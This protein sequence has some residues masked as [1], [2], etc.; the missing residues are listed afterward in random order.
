MQRESDDEAAWLAI[1]ENFGERARL[2]EPAHE[3]PVEEKRDRGGRPAAPTDDAAST[4]GSTAET[5]QP[6]AD[7]AEAAPEPD[8]FDDDPGLGAAW[9]RDEARER[10]R[11]RRTDEEAE[12]PPEEP[13][14]EEPDASAEPATEPGMEQDPFGGRNPW[15]D[16][17]EPEPPA[18]D[19]EDH[20][21][22]PSA[23]PLPVPEPDRGIAWLG[24][25]G[26]PIV[27]LLSLLTGLSFPSW[28]G[29]LL[30]AWF[31]GG[32]VYLVARM[33]REPRDPWDD[34]SRI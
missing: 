18:E 20:F 1:V 27:L 32:F 25:I 9:R 31:V 21:V 2:D 24:V 30:I 19:P 5:D 28:V 14:R 3:V 11:R 22:P 6:A 7:P 23:P 12:A 26:S 15:F 17:P 8:P 16:L 34:G 10:R 29:Y 13:T 4:A 33:D